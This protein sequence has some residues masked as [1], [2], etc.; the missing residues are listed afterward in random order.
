M[1]ICVKY[2]VAIAH[3]VRRWD[4]SP[5]SQKYP[6]VQ[7]SILNKQN[8]DRDLARVV[9]HVHVVFYCHLI[10]NVKH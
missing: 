3:F 10:Q 6:L 4:V 9:E 7:S 1:Q 5:S 2:L 8:L